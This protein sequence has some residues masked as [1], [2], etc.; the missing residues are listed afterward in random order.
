MKIKF[1]ELEFQDDAVKS[2][3]KVFEGHEIKSSEFTVQANPQ[4]SLTHNE[5][6]IANQ[7][8]YDNN[9]LLENVQQIQIA[10]NIP[11]SRS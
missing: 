7:F 2:V 1:E 6:G 10:N 5:F 8:N 11:I 9:R 3:V 4:L